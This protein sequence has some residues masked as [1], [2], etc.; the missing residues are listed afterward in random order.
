[1]HS[2]DEIFKLFQAVAQGQTTPDQALQSLRFQPYREL[3]C[4][5]NLDMHRSMRT[6]QR[7]AVFA[8]GKSRQHLIGAVEGLAENGQPVLVTKA[9]Q[10]Q[11]ASLA[12][13]FP[14]GT[15]WPEAG[16]FVQ[17]K[18]LQLTPPWPQ[19]GDI[20]V[21]TAGA[22]DMA[23]GLEALGTALFYD[24]SAGLISDVGV[25]GLHRL[26]PHLDALQR[27]RVL[28]VVAGMEGALP[29]VLSGLLDKPIIG[30][31]TSVGYGASFSGLSALLGMLSSCA[32]GMSVV[33]ID[34]GFGA[35]ATALKIMAATRA[36]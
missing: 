32:P 33:N 34:N 30:V 20:L 27:A 8:L 12:E 9:D 6:G 31:P 5:L 35:A 7:E 13:R 1:M 29:S 15:F 36:G 26:T 28:V 3:A 23:V 16:L 10:E 18:T 11:G 19:S 21:V 2:N 17:G 24:E 14:E 4:G 25:A 22:S